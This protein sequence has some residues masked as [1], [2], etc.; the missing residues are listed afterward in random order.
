MEADYKIDGNRIWVLTDC[1]KSWLAE[2]LTVG[3]KTDYCYG[4]MCQ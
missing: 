1:A 4:T 3:V 2:T